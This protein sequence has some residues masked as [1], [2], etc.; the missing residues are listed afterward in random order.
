MEKLT[1]WADEDHSIDVA[2]LNFAKTFD[3]VGH[4]R[5]MVKLEAGGITGKVSKWLKDWLRD[6]TQR[7]ILEREASGKVSCE[8]CGLGLCAWLNTV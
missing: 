3:N 4:G 6:R 8:Q 7:V 2:Y 1:A 5:L